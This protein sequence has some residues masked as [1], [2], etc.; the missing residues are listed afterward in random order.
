MS[1]LNPIISLLFTAYSHP[2]PFYILWTS[3]ILYQVCHRHARE[4]TKLKAKVSN[5]PRQCTHIT[6]WYQTCTECLDASHQYQRLQSKQIQSLCQ[7]Y[8]NSIS[9]GERLREIC[10]KHGERKYTLCKEICSP[11][12]VR[13][14]IDLQHIL[15]GKYKY[16][17]MWHQVIQ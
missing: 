8:S 2:S 13:N 5:Q 3:I 11:K 15:F 10:Q 7:M 1:L 16:Q 4:H 9:P 6:K 14:P 12:V 17:Q